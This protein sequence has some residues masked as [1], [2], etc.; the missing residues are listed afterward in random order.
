[1]LTAREPLAS[2]STIGVNLRGATALKLLRLSIGQAELLVVPCRFL[3]ETP[4]VR[5]TDSQALSVI[6]GVG[7]TCQKRPERMKENGYTQ[8]CGCTSPKIS[9]STQP[10][11][12]SSSGAGKRCWG[13]YQ[14]AR[15]A[16][17]RCIGSTGT[18]AG[19]GRPALP[20]VSKVSEDSRRVL[21]EI[22]GTSTSSVVVYRQ[23]EN[24][25]TL[26]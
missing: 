21:R 8:V 14:K 20:A 4:D 9:A 6:S 16:R 5:V 13:M 12:R 10:R 3:R 22:T 23:W 2:D 17:L 19:Q 26:K 24:G 25:S 7:L 18:G 1:M 15:E 11:T